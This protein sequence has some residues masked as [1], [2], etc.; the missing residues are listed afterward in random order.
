MRDPQSGRAVTSFALPADL[1]EPVAEARS[2][3]HELAEKL[4]EK[5]QQAERADEAIEQARQSDARAAG[6]AMA[7][8]KAAPKDAHKGEREAR[9]QAAK[10]RDEV[11]VLEEAVDVAGTRLVETIEAAREQWLVDLGKQIATAREEFDQAVAAAGRALNRL[12]GPSEVVPWLS[13]FSSFKAMHK[14]DSLR[15]SAE[16]SGSLDS[17]LAQAFAGLSSLGAASRSPSSLAA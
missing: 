15:R 12:A 14:N 5:R 11:A 9:E 10:V 16:F 2:R 13:T 7:A 3:F 4:L 6:E 8:G 17:E 1:P